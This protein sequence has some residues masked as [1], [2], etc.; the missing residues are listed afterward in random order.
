MEVFK[1][2]ILST[3][4]GEKVLDLGQNMTGLISFNDDFPEGTKV[5]YTIGE[6]LQYYFL[7]MKISLQ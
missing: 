3:P 4:K 2:K 7:K 6:F 1:P 5:S